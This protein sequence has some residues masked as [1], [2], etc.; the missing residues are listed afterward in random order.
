YGFGCSAHSYD[1]RLRRWSNERDVSKY[2]ELVTSGDSP[3]NRTWNLNEEE[4]RSE[5]VFLGLRLMKGLNT[6]EYRRA[7][8]VDLFVD[9]KEDLTRFSEAGLL[10]VSGNLIRLTRDGA[11]LSNEVFAAFV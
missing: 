8:G 7:F 6:E 10:E 1:G 5:R 9:Y 4:R 2:V 11:L 3:V